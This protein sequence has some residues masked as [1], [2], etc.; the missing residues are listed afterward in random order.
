MAKRSKTKLYLIISI[1]LFFSFSFLW[2]LG[3]VLEENMAAKK[4]LETRTTLNREQVLT[5]A[6]LRSL[7]TE[8]P[9]NS[10]D[11]L[12]NPKISIADLDLS[13]NN[14][15]R[16][17]KNYARELTKILS[18]HS[19]PRKHEVDILLQALS[20]DD[21]RAISELSSRKKQYQKIVDQLLDTETPSQAQ[22]VHLQLI[23]SFHR[24]I[25]I[26][27]DMEKVKTN[28]QLALARAE[29]FI[30]KN[31]YFYQAVNN[32]NVFFYEQGITFNEEESLSIFA[33]L[34]L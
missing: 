33:N 7:N 4:E 21:P 18:S 13:S 31:L 3:G 16:S 32:I 12:P 14:D 6:V 10:K 22:L 20:T 27:A 34:S 29:E 25:P 11:P 24:L 26:L 2:W 19:Q 30:S 23:N 5:E 1:T 17:L 28:P 8:N 15:T 9:Q